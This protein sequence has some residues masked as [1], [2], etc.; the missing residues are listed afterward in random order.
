MDGRRFD[1][2]PAAVDALGDAAEDDALGQ[3]RR[4]PVAGRG[5]RGTG[6]RL[7]S[8]EPHRDGHRQVG[9]D[10]RPGVR[11]RRI[12]Q[13]VRQRLVDVLVVRW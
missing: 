8:G 10:G 13:R 1:G 6:D 3:R 2:A 9:E 12:G 4:V 11:V 5:A 7:E